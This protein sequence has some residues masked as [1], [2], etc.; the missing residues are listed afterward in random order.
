M[1]AAKL[2]RRQLIAATAATGAVLATGP[3]SA[4]E[5]SAP[6]LKGKSILITGCSSGFGYLGAIHYAKLGAKVFA[7]MRGLPRPEGAALGKAAKDGKLDVTLLELDVLSDESVNTAVAEAERLNGGALDVI[8]NNAGIGTGAP[9]ELQDI[10]AMQLLFETN[11]LGYQRVARAALP[12]MRAKKS[13]AIFNVSS[14]LGR[15]MVPG[16]GL[17]SSTKFAVE[18]MSEQ[19]AY[20]LVP[21]GVDVTIVQPG[22]FP[23]KIWENGNKLTAPML[24]RADEERKAAYPELVAGALR[25][26]G[27]STD[28]MDIPRAIASII[29]MAPG[30]RP[31]RLPV[32]PGGKPQIGINDVSA[33]T[34]VAM[35][36]NSPFGPWVKDVNGRG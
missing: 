33:K 32:H 28:P 9:V 11:V 5:T 36:G 3:A 7:T 1:T 17:Y 34:Q 2:N 14:Q 20:E 25:D 27:G 22:G 12:A 30:K 29:A 18:S 26:G 23:T 15:V 31:L 35:L 13:G 4:A 8:I 16:M 21:H 19:M 24:E 10:E 6:D